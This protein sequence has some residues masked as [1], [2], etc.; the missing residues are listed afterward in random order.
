MAFFVGAGAAGCLIPVMRLW[1]FRLVISCKSGRYACVG[2]CMHGCV[3]AVLRVCNGRDVCVGRWY[4]QYVLY[5][6][7]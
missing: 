3:H 4:S 7:M 1:G 6:T 2:A 5:G